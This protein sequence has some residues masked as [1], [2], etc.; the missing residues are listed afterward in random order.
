ML[1]DQVNVLS[2]KAENIMRE[3]RASWEKANEVY[4]TLGWYEEA[5]SEARDRADKLV[6]PQAPLLPRFTHLQ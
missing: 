4:K 6:D 3:A 5:A 2:D 1:L